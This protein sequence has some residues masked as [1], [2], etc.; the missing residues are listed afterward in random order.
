MLADMKGTGQPVYAYSIFE[1]SLDIESALSGLQT[2]GIGKEAILAVPLDRRDE[3]GM[4]F[5]KVNSSDGTSML[6]LGMILGMIG[7]LL[8]SILGFRL[9]WGPI[10]W[11]V[12]GAAAGFLMG[13]GIRLVYARTHGK[14]GKPQK[15]GVVVVVRC[16][17]DQ[18]DWVK[19][20]LWKNGAMGVSF[21]PD[22]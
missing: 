9:T 11:G 14:S 8:G 19:D 17:P 6:A 22:A 15:T 3:E 2:K 4:L 13:F 20:L 16:G 7:T 21:Y 1:H 10:L 12:I 5:D 18:A